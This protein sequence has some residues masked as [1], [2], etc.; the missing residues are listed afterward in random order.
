MTTAAK[1][2]TGTV[3]QEK[4]V[5]TMPQNKNM[6]EGMERLSFEINKDIFKD[7][8]VAIT[9]RK[10]RESGKMFM[11]ISIDTKSKGQIILTVFGKKDGSGITANC[12][13]E[14]YQW[15]MGQKKAFVDNRKTVA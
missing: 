10:G 5:D 2:V 3:A 6:F 14:D 13:H 9:Y 8:D 15:I 4:A 11:V 12:N 7:A 1:A